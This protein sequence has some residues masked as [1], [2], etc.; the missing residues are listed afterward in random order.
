MSRV[1]WVTE[2]AAGKLSVAEVNVLRNHLEY[3]VTELCQN[4]VRKTRCQLS[5]AG[6]TFVGSE[7]GV[8]TIQVK[9]D[10]KLP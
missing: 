1:D 4:F 7:H 3:E 8:L 2:E 10:V 9:T 5:V 6:N